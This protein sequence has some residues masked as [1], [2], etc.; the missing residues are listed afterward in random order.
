[1]IWA[2]VISGP[3]SDGKRSLSTTSVIVRSTGW[4][5]KEANAVT[6]MSAP[7]SSRMLV[8]IF[9]A[10]YSNTS[11]G[12]TSRSCFVFFLKIAIRVSRSGG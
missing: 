6:R 1:M 2:A 7:S 10:M 9:D 11:G 5:F 8:V 12:A 4:R 3:V